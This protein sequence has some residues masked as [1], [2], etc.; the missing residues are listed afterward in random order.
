MPD[1]DTR[2]GA[3]SRRRSR[4]S[5]LGFGALCV[6]SVALAQCTTSTGPG[7]ISPRPP[8]S[9][10]LPAST[11][12]VVTVG[13][14]SVAGALGPVLGGFSSSFTVPPASGAASVTFTLSATQ[15]GGSPVVQSIRRSPQT[16]G[17]TGTT[18]V[19]FMTLTSTV[20]VTLG[21]TPAYSFTVPAG[22]ITAGEISY[23]A[24]YDPTA[25]PQTGWSTFAGPGTVSGNT[26][27][28]TGTAGSDQLTAGVTYDIVLFTVTSALGSP[29]GA[30]TATPVPTPSPTASPSPSPTATASGSPSPSPTPTLTPEA[31]E[32]G[33]DPS[34]S[35]IGIP[36]VGSVQN[37][38]YYGVTLGWPPSNASGVLVT[39][40]LYA[41]Q[42]HTPLPSGDDFEMTL[43]LS[44][45]ATFSS[46]SNQFTL[47]SPLLSLS[48]YYTM[49]VSAPDNTTTT[50]APQMPTMGF[51]GTFL[52]F[53]SPFNGLNVPSGGTVTVV[54]AQQ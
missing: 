5:V 41:L 40:V 52:F 29:S 28:F 17:G 35:S 46:S 11:S 38:T 12:T 44:G 43:T 25:N 30:P 23:L 3:L 6:L 2:P 13:A 48:A 34:G 16:I 39:A 19:V 36:A 14:S 22:T 53:P 4:I 33:L 18:P 27:T 26:V 7:N 49:T 47:Q 42:D 8:T 15:P 31:Y 1:D 51:P 24:V 37:G 9:A 10:P 21:A 32:F 50:T 45:P 54:V 20:T